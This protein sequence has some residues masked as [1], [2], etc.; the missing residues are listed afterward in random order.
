MPK[1]TALQAALESDKSA[2]LREIQEIR[3]EISIIN[4]DPLIVNKKMAVSAKVRRLTT[5]EE[6]AEQRLIDIDK[7]VELEVLELTDEDFLLQ[8]FNTFARKFCMSCK[9]HKAGRRSLPCYIRGAANRI[10]IC[11]GSISNGMFKPPAELI[12]YTDGHLA[13]T[14]YKEKKLK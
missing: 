7:G 8:N 4:G 12:K 9:K 2:L 11:K 3:Q 13:C 5:L 6:A 1:K 10:A 14:S